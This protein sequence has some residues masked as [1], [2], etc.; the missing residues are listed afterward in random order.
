MASKLINIAYQCINC[1]SRCWWTLGVTWPWGSGPLGPHH[2]APH[3][4]CPP[5]QLRYYLMPSCPPRVHTS[6]TKKG[7]AA[8]SG[9]NNTLA[10]DHLRRVHKLAG[11]YQTLRAE[12]RS[13]L[14]REWRH[15]GVGWLRA[16]CICCWLWYLSR[17]NMS[18]PVGRAACREVEVW[19]LWRFYEEFV[20]ATGAFDSRCLPVLTGRDFTTFS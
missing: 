16:I 2:W 18:H 8:Q 3:H 19:P 9:Q 20:D 7:N 4:L 11:D 1:I 6:Q 15:C 12:I 17:I 5:L 14:R 13:V 10:T